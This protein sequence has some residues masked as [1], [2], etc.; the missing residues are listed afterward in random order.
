MSTNKISRTFFFIEPADAASVVVRFK[1]ELSEELPQ[2]NGLTGAGRIRFGPK[3]LSTL[4]ATTAKISLDLAEKKSHIPR[5]QKI[6]SFQTD[7]ETG[8]TQRR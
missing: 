3:L 4:T 5:S 1:Q 2:M 7:Q 8:A 6:P